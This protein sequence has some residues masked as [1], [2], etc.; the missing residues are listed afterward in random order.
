MERPSR[1]HSQR[2][3]RCPGCGNIV[4]LVVGH[5]GTVFVFIHNDNGCNT[6]FYYRCWI[7]NGLPLPRVE[8]LDEA[9][10]MHFTLHPH[11]GDQDSTFLDHPTPAQAPLPSSPTHSAPRAPS[12]P[13]DAPK[14]PGRPRMHA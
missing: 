7:E 9:N 6:R 2:P 13:A 14:K 10:A 3:A 12:R 5:S 1:K 11:K 4:H 8:F